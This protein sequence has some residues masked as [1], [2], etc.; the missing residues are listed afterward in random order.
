MDFPDEKL[1]MLG[2]KPLLKTGGGRFW[3]KPIKLDLKHLIT[4][5]PAISEH[6]T[7]E[8]KE[9]SVQLVIPQGIMHTYN[10]SQQ[11]DIINLKEFIQHLKTT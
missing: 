10:E 1:S 5:E 8:M 7:D 3:L 4:L 9:Q 2:V 6:Q 11:Y